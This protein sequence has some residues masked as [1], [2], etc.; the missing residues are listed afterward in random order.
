MSECNRK[1]MEMGRFHCFVTVMRKK[2]LTW[3]VVVMVTVRS[4]YITWGTRLKCSRCPDFAGSFREKYYT[5]VNILE[6]PRIAGSTVLFFCLL[7]LSL[8]WM[9]PSDTVGEGESVQL[10]DCIHSELKSLVTTCCKQCIYS[11]S[12]CRVSKHMWSSLL[13]CCACCDCPSDFDAWILLYCVLT[14]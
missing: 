10:C 12:L 2:M 9:G 11:F 6:C 13:C 3:A 5:G 1:G 14:S 7:P 8:A 4:L